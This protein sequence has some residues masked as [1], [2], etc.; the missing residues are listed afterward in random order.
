MGRQHTIYLSDDTWK[1]MLE[2][3]REDE[4]MSGVIRKAI[5]TCAVNKDQFDLIV[6]QTKQLDSMK[7]RIA[8]IQIRVCNKCHDDLYN[9][10]LID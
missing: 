6:V 5:Y 2:L 8:S 1:Q 7:R 3:K 4:T 10:G 9:K